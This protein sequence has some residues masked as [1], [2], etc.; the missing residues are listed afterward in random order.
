[1][2]LP[3]HEGPPP[4][5]PSLWDPGCGRWLYMP[6]ILVT[7]KCVTSSADL[8]L[9]Y[10]SIRASPDRFRLISIKTKDPASGLS[11]S[12]ARGPK[13]PTR[14]PRLPQL[15]RRSPRISSPSLDVRRAAR[16]RRRLAAPS[17]DV[18][19]A[20]RR[21]RR[22][23]SSLPAPCG[24][25]RECRIEYF[26]RIIVLPRLFLWIF[27][28]LLSRL[29]ARWCERRVSVAELCRGSPFNMPGDT[30]ATCMAVLQ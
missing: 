29:Q 12:L 30:A 20:D 1:M 28:W 7:R 27:S 4:E 23:G 5:A 9:V 26:G 14:S 15:P 21:R 8:P 13:S 25:P 11:S 10:G 22:L 3:C 19:R 16:R 2:D 6:L 18:R 24:R 17:L